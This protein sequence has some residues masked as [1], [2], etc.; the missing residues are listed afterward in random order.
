MPNRGNNANFINL[1]FVILSGCIPAIGSRTAHRIFDE[2]GK[3]EGQIDVEGRIFN[4]H[5]KYK[6][7]ITK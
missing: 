2:H 6:G 4:E 5:G 3:Y 7:R 1:N